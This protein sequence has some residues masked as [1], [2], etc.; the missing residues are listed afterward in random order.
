M[1]G[2]CL[3]GGGNPCRIGTYYG[4][5]TLP[6]SCGHTLPAT[7]YEANSQSFQFCEGYPNDGVQVGNMRGSSP[8]A[9]LLS[10]E[11]VS[12]PDRAELPGTILHPAEQ[13]LAC[14][15]RVLTL[16]CPEA[17]PATSHS[18]LLECLQHT[19]FPTRLRRFVAPGF[20]AAVP[21]IVQ[22]VTPC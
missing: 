11:A 21:V 15:A 8:G 3:S 16:R 9:D 14:R 1:T 2:N 18:I 22:E 6:W 12:F 5:V 17:Q 10:K 7:G 13:I 19:D 4:G 20:A